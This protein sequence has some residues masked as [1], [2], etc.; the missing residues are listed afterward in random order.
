MAQSDHIV[1]HI[2]PVPADQEVAG[3]NPPLV[4][5]L[6]ALDTSVWYDNR[7]LGCDI[8]TP[9]GRPVCVCPQVLESLRG[10]QF[11]VKTG[12]EVSFSASGDPPARYDLVNWQQLEHGAWG[13]RTVGL[14]DAS[15]FPEKQLSFSHSLAWAQGLTQVS[16]RL[17]LGSGSH[18]G[19]LQPPSG[20]RVS[21]SSASATLL[22]PGFTHFNHNNCVCSVSPS[23]FNWKISLLR[24]SIRSSRPPWI[25]SVHVSPPLSN[26]DL[27]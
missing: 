2:H 20:V 4:C 11:Q 1:S 5:G 18:S 6:L 19:Q 21:H 9:M 27:V 8:V 23:I 10:V 7:L 16:F 26:N 17:S 24:H 15:L 13:F 25:C 22:A 3:S 14:Y 12:E